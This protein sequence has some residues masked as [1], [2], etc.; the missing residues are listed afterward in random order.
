MEFRHP[1]RAMTRRRFLHAV[2]AALLSPWLA[3]RA[4]T[5][6]A[7]GAPPES[8][9]VDR[10]ELPRSTWKKLLPSDAYAVLFEHST[11]R[12]Y[13]SSLNDEKRRGVFVC[14][15]CS[16]PLFDSD[17]KFDS[18][19]GW[20]SFF[21]A[22]PGSIGTK[23]DFALILPRTEY[24]C[25]RCK[26]HQGHVFDDGPAPTGLRHCNNGVALRLAPEGEPLPPLRTAP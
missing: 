25:I 12:P 18:G 14:A 17:A 1:I 2:S 21:R 6:H 11:E 4:A 23:R 22:R 5:S 15:A 13:T 19:T 24:H 3:G 7:A 8:V 10:L 26:G 9:P 20:P 16:F